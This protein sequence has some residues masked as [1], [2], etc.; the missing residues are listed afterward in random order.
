MTLAPPRF[1]PGD[2]VRVVEP[3]DGYRSPWAGK[4]GVVQKS[5]RGIVTVRIG[6][7]LIEMAEHLL[8]RSAA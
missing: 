3:R 5:K 7:A 2:L 4:S 6:F 8:Q 1:S